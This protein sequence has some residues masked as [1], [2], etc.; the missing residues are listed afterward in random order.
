MGASST[1]LRLSDLEVPT[2]RLAGS[3]P[4]GAFRGASFTAKGASSTSLRLSDLEVPTVRLAGWKPAPRRLFQVIAADFP[5]LVKAFKVDVKSLIA[6]RVKHAATHSPCL[7]LARQ[8]PDH[9]VLP[10]IV[11]RIAVDVVFIV[12]FLRLL[13]ADDMDRF[14][15]LAVEY[16]FVHRFTRSAHNPASCVVFIAAIDTFEKLHRDVGRGTYDRLFQAGEAGG[17][18]AALPGWPVFPQWLYS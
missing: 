15:R 4:H 5:R 9:F 10:P 3:L 8:Q 7:I 17:R 11:S 16:D 2:V 13:A 6:L 14:G 1:S 18:V 12:A